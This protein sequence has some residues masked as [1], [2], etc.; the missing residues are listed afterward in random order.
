M[1]SCIQKRSNTR[2]KL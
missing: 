1:K 2:K